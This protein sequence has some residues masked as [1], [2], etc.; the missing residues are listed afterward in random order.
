MNVDTVKIELID[1]I[2]SLKDPTLIHRLLEFKKSVAIGKSK[3][4][5]YGSGKRIIGYIADDFNEPLDD[6]KQYQQ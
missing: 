1:W 3:K 2:T 4:K 6:F 5:V